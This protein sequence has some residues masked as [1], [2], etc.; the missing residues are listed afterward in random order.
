M[1]FIALNVRMWEQQRLVDTDAAYTSTHVELGMLAHSIGVPISTTVVG[2]YWIFQTVH[3]GS[4]VFL[5]AIQF[6]EALQ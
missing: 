2:F 5:D 3:H 4:F 1:L 6:L